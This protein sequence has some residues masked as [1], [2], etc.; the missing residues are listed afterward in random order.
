MT[1][2]VYQFKSKINGKI[3]VGVSQNV[4]RRKRFHLS[5]LNRNKHH[6]SY[7]QSH[8]NKYG[9]DDLE[10][11]I[12]EVVK[13]NLEDKEIEWIAK[14]NSFNMGFNL[15]LG[16]RVRNGHAKRIDIQ[17]IAT[18]EI[19]KGKTANQISKLLNISESSVYRLMKGETQTIFPDKCSGHG[20]RWKIL[21][22]K[23]KACNYPK[24]RNSKIRR[25]KL[26]VWNPQT[27]EI[28]RGNGY[29]ELA[30]KLEIH[31]S[32]LSRLLKNKHKSRNGWVKYDP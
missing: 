29:E 17:N 8:V 28:V 7:L 22:S 15:T 9:I 21:N 13:D 31:P 30:K 16:G 19:I 3:Y 18:G 20:T 27:G 25:K 5:C 24:N 32:T 6:N 10:W 11:S 23:L 1:S 26:A 14:L 4:Y 12:L 2:G